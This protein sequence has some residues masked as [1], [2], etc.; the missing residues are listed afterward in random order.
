MRGDVVITQYLSAR[1]T[2]KIVVYSG[3]YREVEENN[4]LWTH[5]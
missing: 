3:T 1:H 2:L 5:S 4:V